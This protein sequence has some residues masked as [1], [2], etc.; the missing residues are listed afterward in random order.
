MGSPPPGWYRLA[1]SPDFD[2]LWDGREWVAGASRP[3]VAAPAVVSKPFR[4]R[5]E[6]R[7]PNGTVQQTV[8]PN[9]FACEAE[10]LATVTNA[11]KTT[12]GGTLPTGHSFEIIRMDGNGNE[13]SYGKWLGK[14]FARIGV[15][16]VAATVFS[17]LIGN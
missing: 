7:L 2:G 14:R 17:F 9:E 12:F 6:Q 11:V 8:F 3:H 16:A 10:A 4:V 1:K 5:Y 13:E 15:V